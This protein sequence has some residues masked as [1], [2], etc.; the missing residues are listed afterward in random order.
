M[1]FVP[2]EVFER[3]SG[4]LSEATILGRNKYYCP[5]EDC[6]GLMEFDE[7]E[8]CNIKECECPYCQ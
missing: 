2:K 7:D 1:P 4:V 8:D 5:F 3:W 6:S